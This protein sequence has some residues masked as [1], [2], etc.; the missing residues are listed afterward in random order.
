MPIPERLARL[1]AG[2][3]W[4][5]GGNLVDWTSFAVRSRVPPEYARQGAARALWEASH[6]VNARHR[7]GTEH[8][9]SGAPAGPTELA[10]A[11]YGLTGAP[12]HMG[13]FLFLQDESELQPLITEALYVGL[14]IAN[15]YGWKIPRAGFIRAIMALAIVE[16]VR[17]PDRCS[18]R[19]RA[20][21]VELHVSS[22]QRT[23]SPRYEQHLFPTVAAWPSICLQHA[24]RHL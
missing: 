20:R 13:R 17:A 2:R 19:Q 9:R 5:D 12:L 10:G 14:E 23:W 16:V 7:A 24:A 8:T 15:K 18:E 3:T 1:T 4:P 22:W 11:L 6:L 21:A